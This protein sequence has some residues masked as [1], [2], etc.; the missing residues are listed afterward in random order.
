MKPALV[1]SLLLAPLM[2]Q[3]ADFQII[4]ARKKVEAT[5]VQAAKEGDATEATEKWVFETKITNASFKPSPALHAEYI[6]FVERQELGKKKG[7][8]RLERVTGKA[9]IEPMPVQGTSLFT[10]DAVAL[11]EQALSGS[12][13]YRNGGLIKAK[14]NIKGIWIKLMDGTRVAGEYVNPSTLQAKEKW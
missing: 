2:L 14:D 3:A 12:F 6:I 13:H 8:E 7:L 10:T 5:K 4:A 1:L 9:E 11:N